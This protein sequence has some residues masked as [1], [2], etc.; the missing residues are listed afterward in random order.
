MAKFTVTGMYL[1]VG[2]LYNM[3]ATTAPMGVSCQVVII[4]TYKAPSWARVLILL[5]CSAS[6]LDSM[7][8]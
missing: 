5:L 4:V 6:S 3:H 2:Y 7:F 1:E 8:C